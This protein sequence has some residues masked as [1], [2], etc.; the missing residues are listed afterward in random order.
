MDEDLK[1][2]NTHNGSV[3]GALEAK[4]HK[5]PKAAVLQKNVREKDNLTHYEL[6]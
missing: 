2:P 6:T 3:S 4:K 5:Q 1:K